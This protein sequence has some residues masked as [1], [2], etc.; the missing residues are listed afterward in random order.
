MCDIVS[1]Q[2]TVI[3][4]YQIERKRTTMESNVAKS[5]INSDPVDNANS[6][7]FDFR[8]QLMIDVESEWAKTSTNT[9]E[10]KKLKRIKGKANNKCA[11]ASSRNF[12]SVDLLNDCV[13][14]DQMVVDEKSEIIKS[15]RKIKKN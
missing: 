7:V 3:V 9:L 15:N 11:T 12:Q 14:E 10:K 5:Q 1:N 8:S 2:L 6:N 13:L 4:I